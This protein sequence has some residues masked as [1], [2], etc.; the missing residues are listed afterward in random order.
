VS[1]STHLAIN[2]DEYD[3]RIRTFIPYYEEML[4]VAAET[5][6]L[7]APRTVVDLGIGTGGLAA[8]IARAVP[9]ASFVGIDEDSG[10]LETAARRLRRRRLRLVHGSFLDAPFPRTNAF[11][12]SFALHHVARPR[13]KRSLFKRVHAALTRDG[14]LVSAD[15]H[16]PA[17]EW[18]AREGR[19]AWLAHLANAYGRRQAE[20]YLQTWAKEDFYTTLETE[21]QLLRSAGFTPSVVWRRDLFAVIA[22]TRDSR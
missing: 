4:T 14:V 12:A 8:R 6:A 10:M 3:E 16:P 17:A 20:R 7:R 1:V 13:D 21:Q 19:S 5:L 22:A 2:L 9:N 11:S 15:C 18:L